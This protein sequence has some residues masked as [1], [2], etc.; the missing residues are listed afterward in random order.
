MVRPPGLRWVPAKIDEQIDKPK[1]MSYDFGRIILRLVRMEKWQLV[2][3][4]KNMKA[5]YLASPETVA[6]DLDFIKKRFRYR[7]IGLLKEQIE[8]L[9]RPVSEPLV[10]IDEREIG[11]VPRLLDLE[12]IMGKILV[13]ASL[14][15]VPVLSSKAWRPKWA[16]YF[17][18]SRRRDKP[19][20]PQEFRFVLRLLTYIPVDLAEK[21]EE[22]IAL[23]LKKKEWPAYLKARSERL[24]QDAMK[25]F[26]RWP[27]EPS[28]EI[29]VGLVDPLLFFPTV[30]SSEEIP[31]TFPCGL[32]FLESD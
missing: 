16:K 23:A 24:S 26:W 4:A 10:V 25:R 6:S 27:E 17:V 8:L 20:S 12:E 11:P 29:K 30:P 3:L 31:F 2:Y 32:F 22:K 19:F 5:F 18:W 1:R 21:E 14:F 7:R 13:L 9:P 15:M 28:G